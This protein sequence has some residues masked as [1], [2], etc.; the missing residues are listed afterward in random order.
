MLS[1]CSVLW[2]LLVTHAHTQRG[3]QGACVSLPGAARALVQSHFNT[4]CFQPD[5]YACALRLTPPVSACG[6]TLVAVDTKYQLLS[7]PKTGKKTK[8]WSCFREKPSPTVCAASPLCSEE[9]LIVTMLKFLL[10]C[11]LAVA[12][13]AE[14]TEEED[15]LV[16]KKTNFDEA[17]QAH[18]NILVEFCE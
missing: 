6:A 9:H 15:V 12:S 18:P 16:L 4:N 13:R 11:S 2:L 14:I 5:K 10:I 7:Q 8:T 17:L 1:L 3:G